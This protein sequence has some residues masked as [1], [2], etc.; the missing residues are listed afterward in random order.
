MTLWFRNTWSWEDNSPVPA[1]EKVELDGK[2]AI[3]AFYLDPEMI[4]E[5]GEYYFF[6]EDAP[7]L[8]TNN[9]SNHQKLFN[10]ENS[11]HYE[12]DRINEFSIHGREDAIIPDLTGTK[13][14]PHY[15]YELQPGESKSIYLRLAKDANVNGGQ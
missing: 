9:E 14:S 15:L 5:F 6:F 8:F 13:V 4:Y 3:R 2:Q 10:G 1:L 11:S 12:K 7:L